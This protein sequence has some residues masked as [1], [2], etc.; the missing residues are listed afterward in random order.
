ME[1][2][3]A[4]KNGGGGDQ[5][6]LSFAIALLVTMSHHNS[7]STVVRLPIF[8]FPI[9]SISPQHTCVNTNIRLIL[10]LIQL[11]IGISTKRYFPAIGTAGFDL[12]FVSGYNLDPCP[13]P[14]IIANT[15]LF[16]F[17]YFN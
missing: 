14:R 7:F 1:T 4:V 13:P 3:R 9:L 15:F 2:R 12:I 5:R 17:R 6:S 10:E 8:P 11:E 16:I